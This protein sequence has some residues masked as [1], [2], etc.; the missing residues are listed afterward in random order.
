MHTEHLIYQH[1]AAD[2]IQGTYFEVTGHADPQTAL[3]VA[4]KE[5]DE[6]AGSHALYVHQDDVAG[7]VVA[8]LTNTRFIESTPTN[9]HDERL[10]AAAQGFIDAFREAMVPTFRERFQK[11][12][13]EATSDW[14]L[15]CRMS[16]IVDDYENLR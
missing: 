8:L 9:K 16:R 5:R 14:D 10:I 3:V 2:P 11:A 12:M 13:D 15:K 6:G 1:T 7:V 4:Q